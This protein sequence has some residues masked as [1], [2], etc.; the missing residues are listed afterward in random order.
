MILAG[1]P[2]VY[3]ATRP[4]DFR[5]GLAGLALVVQGVL[6]HDPFSG[7]IYVFRS[8]RGD[9]LRL[10]AWDRTG[11]LMVHK[12][13]EGGAFHWPK[14]ADGVIRLSPAQFAALFEGLDWKAVLPERRRRPRLA[15]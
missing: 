15:G 3:L 6:G 4:V 11:L 13:L 2:R 7:A 1:S 8:K 9:R 10:V 5:K 14:P 12:Q